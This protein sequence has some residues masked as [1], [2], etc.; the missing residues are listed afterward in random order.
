M[1][2]TI[3]LRPIYNTLKNGKVGKKVIGYE[4]V[5]EEV[6]Y[7]PDELDEY[8]IVKPLTPEQKRKRSEKLIMAITGMTLNEFAKKILDDYNDEIK[9]EKE[10]SKEQ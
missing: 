3:V 10:G 2:L 9:M 7:S 6:A 5:N 1:M 4:T 8:G